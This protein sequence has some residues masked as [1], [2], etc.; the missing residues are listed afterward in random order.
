MS[1]SKYTQLYWVSLGG[2]VFI[3]S[4]KV[5]HVPSAN[6]SDFKT[7]IFSID[8][9]EFVQFPSIGDHILATTVLSINFLIQ[10]GKKWQCALK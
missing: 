7:P 4:W 2:S 10:R 8:S 1:A 5:Y 3:Q 6:I 9:I